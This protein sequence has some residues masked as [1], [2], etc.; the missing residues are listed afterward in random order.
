MFSYTS[1]NGRSESP[2]LGVELHAYLV[3]PM[4][5]FCLAWACAGLVQAVWVYMC[6]SCM[7]CQEM[8]FPWYNLLLRVLSPFHHFWIHSGAL[9]GGVI[10]TS[11]SGLVIPIPFLFLYADQLWVSVLIAIS[12]KRVLLWWVLGDTLL[13][14]FNSMSSGSFHWCLHLAEW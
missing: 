1:S 7:L 14:G 11:H 13:Y 12:C 9:G 6:G 4:F 10:K 5:R 2:Y 8:L 3:S